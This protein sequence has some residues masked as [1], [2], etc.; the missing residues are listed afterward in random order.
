GMQ[1]PVSAGVFSC[2]CEPAR[3]VAPSIRTTNRYLGT[4]TARP[5]A[6]CY[7]DG[8]NLYYGALR[9]TGYKWIDFESLAIRLMPACDIDLVSYFTARVTATERDPGVATRQDAFF[10]ALKAHCTRLEFIEG[11]FRIRQVLGK[12]IPHNHC[13]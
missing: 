9:S 11:Q 6:R 2:A 4:V 5:V 12:R 8:F 13:E 10:R 7:I 3:H 1:A